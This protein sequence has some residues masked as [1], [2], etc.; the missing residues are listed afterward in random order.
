MELPWAWGSQLIR[1]LPRSVRRNS[2]ASPGDLEKLHGRQLLYVHGGGVFNSKREK[3]T[4]LHRENSLWEGPQRTSKQVPARGCPQTIHFESGPL[5]TTLGHKMFLDFKGHKDSPNSQKPN[6]ALV[7]KSYNFEIHMVCL[8]PSC[9]RVNTVA[10]EV[11]SPF[12]E[13]VVFKCLV[14]FD[15]VSRKERKGSWLWPMWSQ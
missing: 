6:F 7:R 15:D 5:P 4:T 12:N 11:G 9:L 3:R 8:H 13:M 2:P 14:T 1:D 10:W